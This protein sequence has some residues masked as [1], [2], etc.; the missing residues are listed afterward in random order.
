M[1]VSYTKDIMINGRML[2]VPVY[3]I[4]DN[5]AKLILSSFDDNERR[6]ILTGKKES[7]NDGNYKVFIYHPYEIESYKIDNLWINEQQEND[8]MLK[9]SFK[10]VGVNDPIVNSPLDL[11]ENN[12]YYSGAN[13]GGKRRTHRNS[14]TRRVHRKRKTLRK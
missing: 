6:I 3:P 7:N 8:D 1:Q 9:G 4:S 12:G 10:V 5:N 2:T 13:Q 11:Y 14:K